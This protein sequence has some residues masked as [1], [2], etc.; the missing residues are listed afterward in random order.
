LFSVAGKE[1]ASKMISNFRENKKQEKK[2]VW[3]CFKSRKIMEKENN[4]QKQ[5]LQISS[6]IIIKQK[7]RKCTGTDI[8]IF[9]FFF[10]LKKL[11]NPVQQKF[12]KKEKKKEDRK[13]SVRNQKLF[14]QLKKRD[15]QIL[16]FH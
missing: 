7:M 8:Y 6:K 5:K 14:G 4:N 12:K 16:K 13:K 9:S 10:K 1:N 11:K 2:R 15:F 3:I